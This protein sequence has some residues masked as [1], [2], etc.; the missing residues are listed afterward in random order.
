MCS[1]A[2]KAPNFGELHQREVR[3]MRFVRSSVNKPMMP[4]A[5]L[6]YRPYHPE[7]PTLQWLPARR[8][9]HDRL[10]VSVAPFEVVKEH[11]AVLPSDPPELPPEPVPLR[12]WVVQD[13]HRTSPPPPGQ[14]SSHLAAV[15]SPQR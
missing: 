11:P 3:R 2:H 8:T 15:L 9:V 6:L 14:H 13:D 12:A 4:L 7:L 10:G 1:R 5:A